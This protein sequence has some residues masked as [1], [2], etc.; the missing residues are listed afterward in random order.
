MGPGLGPREERYRLAAI[1]AGV[2]LLLLAVPLVVPIGLRRSAFIEGARA[3]ADR[4]PDRDGPRALVDPDGRALVDVRPPPPGPG[5]RALR[6]A[7]RDVHPGVGRRR[8]AGR[9]RPPRGAGT[10]REGPVVAAVTIGCSAAVFLLLRG[11]RRAGWER[12]AQLVAGVWLGQGSLTL[13]AVFADESPA[14][15]QEAGSWIL[16]FAVSALAPI[17]IWALWP[18]MGEAP[19]RRG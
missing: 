3:R 4:L 11:F 8:R 14:G 2:P 12:W 9:R 18:R 6:H 10:V 5:H 15:P 7:R 19:L 17:V 1:A 16:L 13:L